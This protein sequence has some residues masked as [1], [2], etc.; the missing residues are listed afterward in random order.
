MIFETWMEIYRKKITRILLFSYLR[1]KMFKFMF[2]EMELVA[3]Y[4]C[5]KI[6]LKVEYVVDIIITANLMDEARMKRRKQMENQSFESSYIQTRLESLLMNLNK[7]WMNG[8]NSKN[9]H[10]SDRF[11]G[12]WYRYNFARGLPAVVCRLFSWI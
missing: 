5:K 7:C 9:N 11:A 10:V 3:D 12:S 8:F 4:L 2:A 6:R 1:R